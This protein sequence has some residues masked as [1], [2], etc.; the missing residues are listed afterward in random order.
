MTPA[1]RQRAYRLR[2]K[3]AVIDAIGEEHQA[4][5]VTLLALLGRDLAVLED[6]A[7]ASMHHALRTSAQ[8]VLRIIVTRYSIDLEERS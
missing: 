5:R 6:K 3:R 1:Q 8:R 7:A 4:S 2:R